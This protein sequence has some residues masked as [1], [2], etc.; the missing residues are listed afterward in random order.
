MEMIGH[1]R[2]SEHINTE[3]AP[4]AGPADILA[5]NQRIDVHD[6]DIEDL[7]D[8]VGDGVAGVTS[9][10][11]AH[12]V[13]QAVT[14]AGQ[15]LAIVAASAGASSNLQVYAAAQEIVDANQDD[16]IEAAAAG[17]NMA[18]DVTGQSS[19]AVVVATRGRTLPLANDLP[20]HLQAIVWSTN[21]NR[22]VHGSVDLSG[23]NSSIANLQSN[24]V[25]R[26]YVDTEVSEVRGL[27]DGNDHT[28]QLTESF[29]SSNWLEIAS[30][31]WQHNRGWMAYNAAIANGNLILT[32][33]IGYVL[34]SAT[35]CVSRIV[36]TPSAGIW[37]AQYASNTTAATWFGYDA[38]RDNIVATNMFGVKLRNTSGSSLTV[39]QV[40]LYTWTFPER[41]AFTRDFSGLHLLVDT[42][43]GDQL[44]EAANVQYVRTLAATGDISGTFAAG[45]RADKIAQGLVNNTA[46]ANGYGLIWY[47]SVSEHRYVDMATQFELDAAVALRA[48][49]V[50]Y[51]A[52]PHKGL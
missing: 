4:F 45:F 18:G 3:A 38:T 16:A 44:R 6:Q 2:E 11:N 49:Q 35:Q 50:D 46:R 9:N 41:V 47:Q 27:V 8:L 13:N 17:A 7:T 48:T 12:I 20:G 43:P 28:H 34:L 19:N 52:S 40:D 29:A 14:D 23:I 31:V 30:G 39:G 22:Y 10:L 5:I 25:S 21:L 32:A 24:A 1:H 51:L 37:S 33:D 36:L 26:S 42:P 15:D